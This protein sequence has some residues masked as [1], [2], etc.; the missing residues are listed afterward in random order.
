MPLRVINCVPTTATY[1]RVHIGWLHKL[2][3][4][5]VDG[6]AVVF[7]SEEWDAGRIRPFIEKW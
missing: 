5:V 3:E 6:G 2:W 7:H 4:V 1:T